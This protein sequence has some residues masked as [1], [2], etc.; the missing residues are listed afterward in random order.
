M[1]K[2]EEITTLILIYNSCL[3]NVFY[4]NLGVEHQAQWLS[5]IPV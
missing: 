4:L 1:T 5:F 3:K 2:G